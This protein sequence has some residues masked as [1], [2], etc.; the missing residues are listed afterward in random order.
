[1]LETLSIS[2]PMDIF[3]TLFTILEEAR[4][5]PQLTGIDSFY[6]AVG[7]LLLGLVGTRILI[8]LLVWLRYLAGGVLVVVTMVGFNN[9]RYGGEV[10]GEQSDSRNHI[11]EELYERVGWRLSRM[12]R[13]WGKERVCVS[14]A[15]RTGRDIERR[16]YED[17]GGFSRCNVRV[18][19]I[20]SLD[21]NAME[22]PRGSILMQLRDIVYLRTTT[23]I[24]M[25]VPITVGII[26]VDVKQF[27]SYC[28]E[29]T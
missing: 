2:I 14:A 20:S 1:M 18:Y 7:S 26:V 24:T 28:Y 5:L 6:L 13:C 3:N 11:G 19:A 29:D 27:F 21:V 23:R 8:T 4:Q 12:L 22:D 15:L 25:L 16:R 10:D 17:G 9:W